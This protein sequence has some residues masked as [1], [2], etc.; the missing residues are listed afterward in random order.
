MLKGINA[1]CYPQN[2]TLEECFKLVKECG[3]DGIEINMNE[4][5]GDSANRTID[6]ALTLEMDEKDWAVIKALS[7]KYALPISSISSGLFWSNSLTS[8][9]EKTR[10][11]AKNII[12][13]MIDAS[14]YLGVEAILTVPGLVNEEVAYDVALERAFE[15]YSEL[16]PYAEEK[17]VVIGVEN[18]WNKMFLSPLELRDFLD[19]INSDYVK[20]YFDV[21]NVLVS[22]YPEQW[23]KILGNRIVRVHV[24]DFIRSVGNITG[25]TVLYN[26]DVDWPKVNAALKSV[27]YKSYLS[28]ELMPP[29]KHNPDLLIMDTARALESIVQ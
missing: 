20:S 8:N 10:E 23:I 26:G 11:K 2:K 21:G 13:K 19:R 16:A 4:N 7:E 24:K 22:G 29:Y 15:A 12:R 27:G 5:H 3:Y 6:N 28:A 14:S 9:D 18:V 1:W 25:F 17:K